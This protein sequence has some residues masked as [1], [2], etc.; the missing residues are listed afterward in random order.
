M[1]GLENRKHKNV[2]HAE[3]AGDK[4]KKKLLF[5]SWTETRLTKDCDEKCIRYTKDLAIFDRRDC[6][7]RLNLEV[8]YYVEFF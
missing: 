6:R 7:Q 4:N 8:K 1:F 3:T 5:V 2:A